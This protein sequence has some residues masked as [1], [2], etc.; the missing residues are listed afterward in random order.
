MTE[1][2]KKPFSFSIPLRYTNIY[3]AFLPHSKTHI[4][5]GNSY[6]NFPD[7][8][9]GKDSASNAGNPRSIPGLGRSAGEGLGY[10]LQYS[11]LENSMDCI[12]HGVTKNQTQLSNIHFTSLYLITTKILCLQWLNQFFLFLECTSQRK[13]QWSSVRIASSV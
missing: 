4:Q 8:W 11:G 10:P 12:V 2:K 5:Y 7:S 1:K 13:S 9:V 3:S 6:Y